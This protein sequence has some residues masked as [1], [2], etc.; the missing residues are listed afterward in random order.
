MSDVSVNTLGGSLG[1]GNAPAASTAMQGLDKNTFLQLL[2]AQMKYQNPMSPA[3][4]NQFLAQ[5]A[6]YASVEQLENMAQSQADL[7]SMQMI[8]VATGLVGRQ[9]TAFSDLT[10]EE[11]HGVVQ[12]VRFG[13]EPILIVEGAEIP[14]SGVVQVDADRASVDGAA[15]ASA[16]PR[17]ATPVSAA[18]QPVAGAATPAAQP[19]PTGSIGEPATT[20]GAITTGLS[21]PSNDPTVAATGLLTNAATDA[22]AEQA[23]V[24]AA[25]EQAATDAAAEQ[26]VADAAAASAAALEQTLAA[27]QAAQIMG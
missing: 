21:Q 9:V 24:D 19:A 26:A 15:V 7:K 3:D 6:Q 10:G 25:T 8:T 20:E 23:A 27:Y 5:A 1:A 11:V 22:A 16:L 2:V 17:A 18:P 4:S 13:A 14:L 12:T